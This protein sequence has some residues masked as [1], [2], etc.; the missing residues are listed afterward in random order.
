MN[1]LFTVMCEI[2]GPKELNHSVGDTAHFRWSTNDNSTIS[3]A[4]WGIKN[5]N[6]ADPQF[7]N[8]DITSSKVNLNSDLEPSLRNRVFFVGDLKKG[9][10]WFTLKNVTVNDT[11]VYIAVIGDDAWNVIPYPVVLTVKIREGKE[12]SGEF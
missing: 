10:A 2:T 7:I 4:T 12:K 5:A 11:K 6:I 1:G 9:H 8:V 3:S